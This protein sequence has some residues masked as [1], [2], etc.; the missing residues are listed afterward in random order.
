MVVLFLPI[1]TD[2]EHRLVTKYS[3]SSPSSLEHNKLFAIV[4][5][6]GYEKFL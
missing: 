3:I 1:F 2:L 5:Y 4:Q 6:K